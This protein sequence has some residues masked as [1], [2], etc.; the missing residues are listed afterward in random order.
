[1]KH[2]LENQIEKRLGE[3]E[4]GL[5]AAPGLVAYLELILDWNRRVDL[6]APAANEVLIER[7][8][9]DSLL[10]WER[11]REYAE[12][13]G[14]VLDVGS[15]AGLPGVVVA[16]CEPGRKVFL[17]EP[18]EKRAVFLKEVRRKL[19][20]SNL[21]VIAKRIE[22]VELGDFAVQGSSG[23]KLCITRA[24]GITDVFL[25]EAWRLIERQNAFACLITGPGFNE[26]HSNLITKN[27][28]FHKEIKYL[29]PDMGTER[30]LI[31]WNVSRETL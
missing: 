21:E 2:S 24:L 31:I 20:L 18:R 16:I 9:V 19:G 30:R 23:I 25:R 14:A 1:M 12:A 26:K 13:D 15:G 3:L 7:H 22:E 27:I 28:K 4:L 5:G 8:F 17:C 29:L 6:V 11:V 10:A